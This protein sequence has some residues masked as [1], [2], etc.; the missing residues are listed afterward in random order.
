MGPRPRPS[1]FGLNGSESAVVVRVVEYLPGRFEIMPTVS[2]PVPDVLQTST[3]TFP[4]AARIWSAARQPRWTAIARARESCV[5]VS[6]RA[7]RTFSFLTALFNL[8][9]A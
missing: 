9:K 7:D 5:S 1:P 4:V 2:R 3:Q 6:R 8:G